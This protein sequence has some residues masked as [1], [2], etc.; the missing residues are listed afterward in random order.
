MTGSI[1]DKQNPNDEALTGYSDSKPLLRTVSDFNADRLTDLVVVDGAR[2]SFSILLSQKRHLFTAD[3][4]FYDTDNN[5]LV[6]DDFL[7]LAITEMWQKWQLLVFV[8]VVS[9]LEVLF[10][11]P[12]AKGPL[13][14]SGGLSNRT[15][16]HILCHDQS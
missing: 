1:L 15:V 3:S 6:N 12:S 2:S 10:I 11:L 4:Q 5:G 16:G 9:W 13:A 8:T 14:V 7:L